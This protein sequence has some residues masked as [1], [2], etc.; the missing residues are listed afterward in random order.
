MDLFWNWIATKTGMLDTLL[1]MV[2]SSEIA[3]ADALIGIFTVASS[4]EH[5][6]M[7]L[8]TTG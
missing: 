5:E 2:E 4:P 1:A 6:A 3:H 7:A 8:P